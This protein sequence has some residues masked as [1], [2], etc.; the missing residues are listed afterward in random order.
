MGRSNS[1]PVSSG[2]RRGAQA[3]HAQISYQELGQLLEVT[4][5]AAQ[6]VSAH[7]RLQFVRT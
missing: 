4:L 3:K 5:E 7:W 6:N 1:G 2:R